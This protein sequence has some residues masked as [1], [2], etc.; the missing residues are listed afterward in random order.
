MRELTFS[1]P[2]DWGHSLL[3]NFL[4]R[5]CDVSARL[6][7][8]LKREPGGI[9]VNG[10]HATALTLLRAG[11]AVRLVL[12]ADDKLPTPKELPIAIVY[13][14]EDLLVVD[15][16]AD[17][18]VYPTPGH[19][20]DTLANAVS[21]CWRSKGRS[22]SFRPVYR[23][24]KNTSGLIVLAKN[25]Y[26]ASFLSHRIQKEYTAVCEGMLTGSG[27]IDRPILLAPGSKIRR[28]VGPAGAKAVTRWESECRL[29]GHT[30][31]KLRLET[32]RTHQ[33]RV[34]MASIG[35]PLAG[36][37]LYGGHF[38]LIR[39][40]ALHCGD[41]RLIHPVEKKEMEL[42]SALPEDMEKLLCLC[43]E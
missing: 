5:R 20:S 21:F 41:V 34:H 25:A 28:A 26:A 18:P 30:L 27:V 8:R 3:K 2:R 43:H 32:G 11:D 42:S 10:A 6:L 1:V 17:M 36:D 4:R 39:R 24:D 9:S 22:F 37:D 15:K 38:G 12:P 13:E 29:A 40:Q 23:L 35:H 16:P 7:A 31:L 33:I 14:D 19:D